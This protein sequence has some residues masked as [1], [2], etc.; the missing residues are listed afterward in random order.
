MRPAGGRPARSAGGRRARLAAGVAAGLAGAVAAAVGAGPAYADSVREAQWHLRYLHAAEAHA[1]TQGDGVIVAI[2]DSGVDATHPDLSGALLPGVRVVGEETPA[3]GDPDGRG[4]ALAGLV[5]GHGHGSDG[6][7]GVLGLAPKAKV[8][9]VAV[10][11]AAPLASPGPGDDSAAMARG[12]DL[13]VTRGAKVICVGRGVPDSPALRTAV[14]AAVR[15]GAVVVAA[16]GNRPGEDAPPYP[17]A[18]PGVVAAVPLNR[19]LTVTVASH[20]GRAL[21][22]S[23]PGDDIVSTNTGG[24]YRID[25]GSA[26]VGVLAGAVALVRAAYP[27]LAGDEV[28]HRM[29]ATAGDAGAPGRD[30]LYGYG[31]LDLLAALTQSVPL[32]HPAPSA[33][34]GA[35]LPAPAATRSPGAAAGRSSDRPRGVFGWLVMLPLLAVLGALGWYAYRA[36]RDLGG[37]LQA[38]AGVDAAASM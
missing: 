18:Y 29:T 24:G 19:N 4:T 1:R 26:A 21:G 31:R 34:A 2:L 33:S 11:A 12:I 3:D 23:V 32:L 27:A 13:A 15:A 14:E 16:D 9:P 7:D 30:D 5:A 37:R 20:S 22:L 6:A 25:A 38:G 17:A 8:L 36:E 10:T 35:A 28:V